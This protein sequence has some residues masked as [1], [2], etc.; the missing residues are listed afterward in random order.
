MLSY[1]YARKKLLNRFCTFATKKKNTLL[2]MAIRYCLVSISC[3]CL[4]AWNSS[5]KKERLQSLLNLDTSYKTRKLPMAFSKYT[6]RL[7]KRCKKQKQKQKQ[8]QICGTDLMYRWITLS[9]LQQELASIFLTAELNIYFTV[10]F[11]LVHKIKT[12]FLNFDFIF[13]WIFKEWG[14]NI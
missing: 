3:S 6:N 11:Q 5:S 13:L 9:A 12:K 10:D 7:G 14:N 4:A 1:K 8:I 2:K